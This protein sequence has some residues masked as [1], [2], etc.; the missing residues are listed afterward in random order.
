M[1]II[2]IF[3]TVFFFSNHLAEQL[4][5]LQAVA[6]GYCVH[7]RGGRFLIGRLGCWKGEHFHHHSVNLS[8]RNS[9]LRPANRLKDR[10]LESVLNNTQLYEE[11]QIPHKHMTLFTYPDSRDCHVIAEQWIWNYTERREG[12]CTSQY[13]HGA[14][15]TNLGQLTERVIR[16]W[17]LQ[18]LQRLMRLSFL[19]GPSSCAKNSQSK[20]GPQK[21]ENAQIDSTHGKNEGWKHTAWTW[22]VWCNYSTREQN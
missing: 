3:R 22:F 7:R 4:Q 8:P 11:E 17:W 15:K 21:Q 10:E 1:T 18:H 12:Y 16:V 2:I 20:S 13:W 14:K 9:S 5:R 19:A 6:A